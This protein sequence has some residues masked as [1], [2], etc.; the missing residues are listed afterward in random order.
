MEPKWLP[1]GGPWGAQM[2]RQD[3][4]GRPRET[5]VSPVAPPGPPGVVLGQFWSQI[6]VPKL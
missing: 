2:A 6:W 3:P 1:G 4:P 5:P